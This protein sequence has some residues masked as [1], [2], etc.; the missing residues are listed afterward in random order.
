MGGAVYGGCGSGHHHC[1]FYFFGGSAGQPKVAQTATKR[2]WPSSAMPYARGA[3]TGNWAPCLPRTPA[4]MGTGDPMRA[5]RRGR[6]TPLPNFLSPRYLFSLTGRG[7]KDR[8]ILGER[9]GRGTRPKPSYPHCAGTRPA[10]VLS[11]LRALVLSRNP[12]R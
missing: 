11:T 7:V 9:M 3:G 4:S 8:G 12:H 6:R 1:V 10:R 2:A 5:L